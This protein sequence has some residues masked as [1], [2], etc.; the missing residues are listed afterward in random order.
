LN[1]NELFLSAEVHRWQNKLVVGV[2]VYSPNDI[3]GLR[4]TKDVKFNTK[5]ASSMRMMHALRFLEK[6][7][8]NMKNRPKTPFFL[9]YLPEISDIIRMEHIVIV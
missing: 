6:V 1:K 8:K 5:V 2:T 7:V 3:S 4:R 9:F